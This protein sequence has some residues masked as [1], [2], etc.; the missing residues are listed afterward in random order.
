[1]FAFKLF[2]FLKWAL[3]A[4]GVL[5]LVLGGVL[6]IPVK[7]PP[8]LASIHTGARAIGHE[9]RPELSRFQ[10]RDGTW[11]AYR[12]YRA[13]NGGSDRLVILAHGSSASSDEMHVVARSLAENGVTAVA[14]DVRGHGASG[15][16]G[17]VAY[18]GQLDDDL[19]DL[20]GELRR[21]YA[22]AKLTLIGHSSGG[23]FALR[24]A[25][26]PVGALFDRFVLLAP[27]LGHS[28]PTN[29][30]AEPTTRWAEPD[31]PRILALTFLGLIGIDWPQSL[32][33]IAF[34]NAPEAAKSVTSRYSFRLLID[35]GPPPDWQGAL[36][37]A[38]SRLEVI[39][40][41]SDEL[42]DAAV[43]KSVLP[44]LGVH[45]VLLPNVDHMGVVY[46]PTALAAILE[47]T[48]GKLTQ[49]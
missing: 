12:L 22:D 43:Y 24:I 34:A 13:K 17:D 49:R 45:V 25:A 37:K 20:V 29:R 38:A 27:Y 47:T 33:V 14:I 46:Q 28:A 36:R 21:S 8:P 26:G 35:Y 9:G 15:T 41:E 39:A 16:R 42:M 6:A 4:V 5:A 31:I 1:M 44:P 40:G 7:S 19:T 30:P 32:P 11:L 48:G 3:A 10:A 2:A 18:I 23:G